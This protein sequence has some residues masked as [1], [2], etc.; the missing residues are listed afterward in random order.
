MAQCSVDVPCQKA[1]ADKVEDQDCDVEG[2]GEK[3][4]EEEA[5]VED[6]CDEEGEERE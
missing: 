2:E 6:A 5:A 4:R 1:V 3:W